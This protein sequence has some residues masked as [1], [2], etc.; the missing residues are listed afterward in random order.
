MSFEISK[1][2][3]VTFI[4]DEETKLTTVTTEP[5][6]AL[7]SAKTEVEKIPFTGYSVIAADEA[8][9][10]YK[11]LTGLDA[12]ETGALKDEDGD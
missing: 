1:D 6:D 2:C 11:W 3:T 9:T 10:G 4:F 7:V 8:I 5:Q 12:A